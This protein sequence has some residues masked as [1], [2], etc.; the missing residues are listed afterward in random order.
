[1]NA[2]TLILLAVKISIAVSVFALGLRA[3]MADATYVLRRPGVLARALVSMNVIVPAFALTMAMAFNLRPAVKLALVALAVSPVPPILPKKALKAG[4]REDYTFGLLVAAAV[5]SVFLVP[6]AVEVVQRVA[7]VPLRM[8]FSSVALIVLT[9]VLAPL[10]AGIAIRAAAPG[11]A[12]KAAGPLAIVASVL[13][14]L[15]V[16]AI[17]FSARRAIFALVG[18]GTLISLAAFTVVGLIAGHLLGGPEPE[19]RTVLALSSATRHPGMAFAIASA[20]FPEARAASMA[21]VLLAV[22]VGA[23]VSAPYLAW[24]RRHGQARKEHRVQV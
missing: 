24:T 16:V 1:M 5:L 10:A 23:I 15:G 14:L 13:L 22:L 11:L 2:A 18:D 4:G 12:E 20:N 8:T 6:I 7:G 19:N 3:T 17:L 21:A 9:T